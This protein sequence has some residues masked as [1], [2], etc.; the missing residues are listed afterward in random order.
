MDSPIAKGLLIFGA[1]ALAT[2][3][4]WFGRGLL[5]EQVERAANEDNYYYQMTTAEACEAIGGVPN[6]PAA[7]DKDDIPDGAAVFQW[8]G[9]DAD[10]VESESFCDAP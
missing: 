3:V 2:A 10:T 7:A 9:S 1:I 6:E 4:V 8:D 5:S